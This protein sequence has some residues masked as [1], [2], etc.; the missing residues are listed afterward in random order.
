MTKKSY[1]DKEA[2]VY[3]WYDIQMAYWHKYMGDMYN[4]PDHWE[5][6]FHS[7]NTD[8]WWDL[9][10]VADVM[11]R[12]YPD[13]WRHYGYLSSDLDELERRL[14]NSK[15]VIKPKVTNYNHA[16]FRFWMAFKD[17]LNDVAG[18]PTRQYTDAERRRAHEAANPTP[19]ETL[20]ERKQ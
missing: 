6:A 5:D 2:L 19:F 17:F 7:P 11:K 18:T 10:D 15:D 3:E 8:N 12:K 16:M 14:K 4:H 9:F 13:E 20:F 1:A